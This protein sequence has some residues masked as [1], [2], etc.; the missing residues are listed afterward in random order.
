MNEIEK[1]EGHKKIYK[2]KGYAHRKLKREKEERHRK[3]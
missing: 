1:E 3:G 2:F